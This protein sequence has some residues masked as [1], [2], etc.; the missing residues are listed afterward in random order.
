[1]LSELNVVWAS[2]AFQRKPGGHFVPR[3]QTQLL[4]Q[5]KLEYSR[6][7]SVLVITLC[8]GRTS[9][10]VRQRAMAIIP[11]VKTP[12][13]Q[14]GPTKF[15]ILGVKRNGTVSAEASSGNAVCNPSQR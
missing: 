7:M 2:L 5:I 3:K 6:G 13:V 11:E 14:I 12:S 9:G 15:C 1:M 4:F 10:S 8:E